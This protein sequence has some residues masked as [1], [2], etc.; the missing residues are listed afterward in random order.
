MNLESPL[1]RLNVRRRNKLLEKAKKEYSSFRNNNKKK[2]NSNIKEMKN[3]TNLPCEKSIKKDKVKEKSTVSANSSA[4]NTSSDKLLMNKRIK[5]K[6]VKFNETIEFYSYHN[7]D[8]EKYR[9]ILW[10]TENDTQRARDK[11]LDMV[12]QEKY[13]MDPNNS[14]GF[15]K[16]AFKYVQNI[17]NGKNELHNNNK[18]NDTNNCCQ[19][20]SYEILLPIMDGLNYGY[21]GILDEYMKDHVKDYIAIVLQTYQTYA[22]LDYAIACQMLKSKSISISKSDIIFASIIGK[23]CE[24]QQQS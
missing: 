11:Q 16:S 15:R 21:H 13:N 1:L 18:T 6:V 20:I 7:N 9:S 12:D 3:N 8:I 14:A 2:N 23:I 19:T 10:W 24:L 5:N 4:N 22:H 17:M